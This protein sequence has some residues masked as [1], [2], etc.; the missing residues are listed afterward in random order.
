MSNEI[1]SYLKLNSTENQMLNCICILIYV[2]LQNIS[3]YLIKHLENDD[4]KV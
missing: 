2:S 1:T 4:R 3:L